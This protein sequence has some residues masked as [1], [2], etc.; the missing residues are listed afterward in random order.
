MVS[1]HGFEPWTPSLKV[2]KPYMHGLRHSAV[3]VR[4]C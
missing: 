2:T 4:F 1:H 3:S